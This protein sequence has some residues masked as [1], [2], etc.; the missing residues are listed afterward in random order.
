MEGR[1]ALGFLVR[2]GVLALAIVATVGETLAQPVV[3][4]TP[5]SWSQG[6][7]LTGDWGGL[8]GRLAEHGFTPYA[9]YNVE[10]FGTVG[11]ASSDGADWTSELEFG[12][13]VDLERLVGLGGGSVHATTAI[14]CVKLERRESFFGAVDSHQRLLASGPRCI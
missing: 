4:P 6:P 8:R 11:D 10:V 1:S 2:S 13:D 7:S 9:T 5:P 12:L 3:D 14:S